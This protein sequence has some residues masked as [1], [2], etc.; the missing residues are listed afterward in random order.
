MLPQLTAQP[1]SP[2]ESRIYSGHTILDSGKAQVVTLRRVP[3]HDRPAVTVLIP[4]MGRLGTEPSS[5]AEGYGLHAKAG[6]ENDE[7]S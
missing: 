3:A 2:T 6:R 4:S 7:P 1:S 5:R